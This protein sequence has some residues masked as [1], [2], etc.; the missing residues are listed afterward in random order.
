M[1]ISIIIVNSNARALLEAC[2]T[3][4][5]AQPRPMAFEVIVVDN[6][7]TDGSVAMIHAQFP[8]V[9]VVVN[10]VNN[11]YAIA[12]NQGLELAQ[13]RY[14]LYA[15][16]DTL[17]H[18][19]AMQEMADFLDT[20]PD[21]GGVGCPLIYPD[22]RF[23]NACFRFPAAVN[24]FYLLCFARFYWN[25]S[26]AG[27]YPHLRHAVRPQPVDFVV[28]A[29]FMARR[30]IL[31]QLSGMDPA[32]YFYGEDSDLCYR[33]WR[34]G[35]PMYYLPRAANVVHYGGGSTLNLFDHNHQR[36]KHLWG[37]K[38][39]FLFV[40][41]HYPLWRKIGIFAAVCGALAL[42]GLLY[43]L[44][45]LKRA[46]WNYLRMN[47]DIQIEITRTAFRIL[48]HTPNRDHSNNS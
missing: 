18:G 23:Q 26:L 47:L 11:R 27:N 46:D 1:D 15:N 45:C 43:G 19:N 14:V 20:H 28:G 22:G 6:A 39:R 24:I 42:N 13:G 48:C 7:S 10:A 33:M 37:W 9:R 31:E 38:A 2:L 40:A 4:I 30:E 36:V 35:W 5:Y 29:C 41:K 34:A 21:A 16:S 8:H 17:L 12:N 3:S 32:Y 44:A 25:T